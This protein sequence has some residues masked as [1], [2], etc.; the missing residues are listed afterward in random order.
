MNLMF[1]DVFVASI[2]KHASIKR[3]VHKKVD[4]IAANPVSLAE[5]LRGNFRGY[6]SCPVHRNFLILFLY[7]HSCRKKKNDAIVLCSDCLQCP[8]D[9]IKFI[10]L[11]PHDSVYQD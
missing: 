10:A 7:C 1:S 6:N 8:D 5:P 4:M 3:A 9:T 11:G 2:K